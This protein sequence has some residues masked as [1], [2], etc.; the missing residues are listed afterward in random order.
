MNNKFNVII[1]LIIILTFTFSFESMAKTEVYFS[2]YDDPQSAIVKSID[3]A[4]DT[5]NIAMYYFTEREI[6]QAVIRA[7]E[8]GI[9]IKIY[10]DKSQV[11]H[12]QSKSRYLINNGI[13]NIRISSNNYIMHNKFAVIDNRIVITGSY[14]WTAYAGE[15]N[16]ENLLIIDD[17]EIVKRYQEYFNTLWNNKYSMERYQELLNH[18]G[19]RTRISYKLSKEIPS[20]PKKPTRYININTASL[21]EL[22]ELFGVGKTIA[23]EIITYREELGDFIKPED[24]KLV[25]GIGDTKWNVWLIDGWEITVNDE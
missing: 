25:D 24:I 10:L 17:E 4:K 8:R 22:N 16:D 6:A 2:L 21:E 12:E 23:Q 7:K 14:N 15:K 5:L 9:D 18:P 19:V 20:L 3:N 13:E 1:I 11:N